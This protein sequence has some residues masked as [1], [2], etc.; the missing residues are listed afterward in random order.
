MQTKNEKYG[1]LRDMIDDIAI[2]QKKGL[3]FVLA[4]AVVWTLIF[5]IHLTPLS[6][7][8]QNILTV[9]CSVPIFIL[10]LFFSKLLG[11]DYF[12][13]SNPL[14]KFGMVFAFNQ[15]L[16]LPLSI[17]AFYVCPDRML[18]M[19]AVIT[20]AHLLPFAWL[21][22]SD[23]YL[24][25]SLII[26]IAGI[27]VGWTCSPKALAIV[28]FPVFILFALLLCCEVRRQR[29]TPAASEETEAAR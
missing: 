14:Y 25:F 6:Q 15:M 21:Y 13:K 23:T 3:H 28:M 9:V 10:A 12:D 27:V 4:A 7:N 5:I 22:R 2:R 26:S 16:Y 24:Y 29:K 8:T 19:L 18:M 20:G 11:V 1:F 17:W